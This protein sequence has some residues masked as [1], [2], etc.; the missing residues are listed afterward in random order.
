MWFLC[1]HRWFICLIS[2]AIFA[3]I[4]L[5]NTFRVHSNPFDLRVNCISYFSKWVYLNNYRWIDEE[6]KLL[7]TEFIELKISWEI[8]MHELFIGRRMCTMVRG[9]NESHCFSFE[10]KKKFSGDQLTVCSRTISVLLRIFTLFRAHWAGCLNWDLQFPIRNAMTHAPK[11][12]LNFSLA[13]FYLRTIHSASRRRPCSSSY[14][15]LVYD[16]Q[17]FPTKQLS[18]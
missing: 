7:S 3:N 4:F 15:H 16:Y 12:W 9:C 13:V 18:I 11:Q 10:K 6:N 5:A 14:T 17:S 2:E 8:I 1:F